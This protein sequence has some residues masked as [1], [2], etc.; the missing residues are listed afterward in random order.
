M[1]NTQEKASKEKPKKTPIRAQIKDA[2][3]NH[4]LTQGKIPPS[5]YVFANELGIGETDFYQEFG[6]FDALH[7]EIWNDFLLTTIQTLQQS[8]E[9]GDYTAREKLLSFYFTMMEVLKVNRSYVLFSY[10]NNDKKELLPSFLK[11]VRTTYLDFI[12]V[13]IEEG[14]QTGEM[15]KR[16]YISDRYAEALWLQFLFVIRFWVKDDSKNFEQS[17]A[18]VEKTVKITF[19]ILG[20]SPLDSFIDLAKFLYQNR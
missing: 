1:K 18:L 19:E 11:K 14:L 16:P 4:L 10:E 17:D 15:K 13:L 9:Y 5:V 8:K 2:F 12:N 7:K 6:S 3:I 20:E